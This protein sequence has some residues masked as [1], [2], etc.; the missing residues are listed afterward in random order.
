MNY[1]AA[2][3]FNELYCLLKMNFFYNAVSAFTR[4]AL[5]M[6][7]E[8]VRVTPHD[9]PNQNQGSHAFYL[10]ISRRFPPNT[11]QREYYMNI[12]SAYLDYNNEVYHDDY[13]YCDV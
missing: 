3:T 4:N 8:S 9:D 13:G 6:L 7:Q 11:L 2:Y 5:H 1:W 10:N 12:A